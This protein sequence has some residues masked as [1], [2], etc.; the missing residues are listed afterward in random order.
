MFPIPAEINLSIREVAD[1]WSREMRSPRATERELRAS[2][3]AAWWRGELRSAD[4]A[5]RLDVLRGLYSRGGHDGIVFIIPG[6]KSPPAL[7][8]PRGGGVEV[9]LRVRVPVPC[10]SP[11]SWTES[12]CTQAF[13]AIASGWDESKFSLLSPGMMAIL[14]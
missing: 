14:L 3:I 8:Y 11:A 12:N 4:E 6:M 2:L 7:K 10:E 5:Q 1:Y 9:D 13:E